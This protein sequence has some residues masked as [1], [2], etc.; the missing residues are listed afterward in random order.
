[1]QVFR[2][3]RYTSECVGSFTQPTPYLS[4][5]SVFCPAAREYLYTCHSTPRIT[6]RG[7]QLVQG[8]PASVAARL[9]RLDYA[10]HGAKW[11]KGKRAEKKISRQPPRTF[12]GCCDATQLAPSF[13]LYDQYFQS[14]IIYKSKSKSFN[15]STLLIYSLDSQVMCQK[16]RS[17]RFFLI[18]KSL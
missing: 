2:R 12:L 11:K 10:I 8:L 3:C 4:Y 15:H 18:F 14:K 5:L 7:S 13:P 16:H 17:M 6:T 1:M 9:V